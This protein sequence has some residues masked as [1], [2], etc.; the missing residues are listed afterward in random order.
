[1]SAALLTSSSICCQQARSVDKNLKAYV[2]TIQKADSNRSSSKGK[3]LAFNNKPKDNSSNIDPNDPNSNNPYTLSLYSIDPQ[4]SRMARAMYV[5]KDHRQV[6]LL[7]KGASTSSVAA[8][9]GLVE[10]CEGVAPVTVGFD[11]FM[12]MG[13]GGEGSPAIVFV[14]KD[15]F[16]GETTHLALCGNG[17]AEKTEG[18]WVTL[19]FDTRDPV[20][21]FP[22]VNP[23]D[24][25]K[26][27]TIV[28]YDG[29][30]TGNGVTFV[31]NIKLNGKVVR[32]V[33]TP[34]SKL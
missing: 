32:E 34:S 7:Q 13:C 22:T 9:G 25:L 21:V 6:I 17:S 16:G 3:E 19:T 5:Q 14:T 18:S 2:E 15:K 4:N 31:D 30:D 33:R 1:M 24:V 20:Q 26:D 8:C 29:Y 28:M 11:K 23:G 27:M 12:P 10:N